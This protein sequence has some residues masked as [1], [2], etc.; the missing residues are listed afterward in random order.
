M[1]KV[2]VY[3]APLLIFVLV[4]LLFS[5]IG[6][7]F[8]F[9]ARLQLLISVLLPLFFFLVVAI[10][11]IEAQ[12]LTNSLDSQDVL[13]SCGSWLE[14]TRIWSKAELGAAL[15]E[16]FVAHPPHSALTPENF[17][18]VLDK[19][20]GESRR[21]SQLPLEVDALC[22]EPPPTPQPW[23]IRLLKTLLYGNR[24]PQTAPGIY[25]EK[26]RDLVV[27]VSSSVDDLSFYYV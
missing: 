3:L 9:R 1:Q 10:L 8:F 15:Q 6:F 22:V 16:I 23:Y 5:I 20:W 4:C 25:T 11:A 13:F 26:E 24:G 14:I 18:L 21:V 19:V 27:R 12:C 2:S 7:S 17:R